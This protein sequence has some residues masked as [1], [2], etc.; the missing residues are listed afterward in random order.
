M[1][2]EKMTEE[3]F[4]II[5]EIK[6]PPRKRK[7]H[8]FP[9]ITNISPIIK[10][11]SN[12]SRS[13]SPLNSSLK[14]PKSKKNENS[15]KIMFPNVKNLKVKNSFQVSLSEIQLKNLNEKLTHLKSDLTVLSEYERTIFKDT[16]LDIMFIM[17]I[18][19]SMGMWLKE[20]KEN[21]TNIIDEIIENNPGSQIRISFIGYR[22][23][24]DLN[25]LKGHYVSL[26]FTNN[27]ND[28]KKFISNIDCY[29]GGD[30]PEDVVG[31]FNIALNMNWISNARYA[32][33]VCD[34]PC[35]GNQYHKIT[36][37]KY[38]DGDPKG[39]ILENLIMDFKNKNITLYC[40]EI[41]DSTKIMFNIMKNI[42]SDEHMFHIENLGNAVNKF[43]FFVAFSASLTLTNATYNK[44]K[45]EDVIENFRNQTIE[46]IVK[47]YYSN[48]NNNIDDDNRENIIAQIENLNLNENE[49]KMFDFI[50]R[51]DSLRLNNDNSSIYNNGKINN[52]IEK[53]NIIDNYNIQIN[54]NSEIFKNFI[55][56]QYNVNFYSIQLS[57]NLNLLINW[58]KVL[59]Q[60]NYFE[61]KIHFLDFFE[62]DVISNKYNFAAKDIIRDCYFDCLLPQQI[63]SKDLNNINLF[64]E[65]YL[66]TPT[67]CSYIADSFNKRIFEEFPI[68][69]Q[70]IKFKS[71]SVIEILN[72]SIV[73]FPTNY[74]LCSNNLSFS[75]EEYLIPSKNILD[76]FSHFSFQFSEGNLLISNLIVDEK[77]KLITNFNFYKN[78]KD[79]YKNIMKFFISHYCNE[80]CY[81]LQLMNP[82]RKKNKIE[83]TSEF[84]LKDK[85]TEIKLC[86]CCKIPIS[87]KEKICVN[88][89][90]IILNSQINSICEKCGNNFNYS[91]YYYNMRMISLP[92]KCE[93]CTF[94]F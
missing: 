9:K 88:C 73:N 77:N 6:T 60:K 17:D 32:V 29:G 11:S 67:I 76:A 40:I 53:N 43:S 14:S 34:A 81:K 62:V 80:I 52:D 18:T 8:I 5:S 38:K 51:L 42:Y 46:M 61:S 83:I 23:F 27:V 28:V 84:F 20:A 35:H 1:K 54:F 89:N 58:N 16:T 10:N 50:N 39:L 66:L 12:R 82:R 92:T 33:L 94:H 56:K 7:K 19:G 91:L 37:D 3:K 22:D 24:T 87:S 63:K 59:Y 86:E 15:K 49:Q 4:P 85:I 48:F 72:N 45:F 78:E 57:N 70:F 47:K 41:N 44:V 79:D 26:D 69:K 93:N 68:L 25:E 2:E 75:S 13:R 64:I 31:A 21:I 90:K 36:Y 74:F 30:E 65:N 55:G 71:F